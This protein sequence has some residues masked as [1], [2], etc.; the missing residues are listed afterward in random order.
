MSKLPLSLLPFLSLL[1]LLTL[2]SLNFYPTFLRNPSNAPKKIHV[3]KHDQTVAESACGGTLY[4]DLCV[5]TVAALPELRRKTLQEV[6][7]HTIN[8]T[9]KEVR[10]S[11][12][13]CTSLRR[14]LL[15]KL[16]PLE[17][18]ALEDCL[19]LFS[20]TVTELNK[21]LADLSSSA[22]PA[23]YYADLQTLLSGAMTNQY[24]CLDGFAYSKNNTR[25]FIEGRLRRISRHVS[26]S[27]AMVK[28]LK[29]NKQGRSLAAAE[30]QF[31]EYGRMRGGFPAWLSRKERRLLQA[32][33]NETRFDLVV[34][35]DGSGNFTTI[36]E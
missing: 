14:K 5:S 20:D 13:N 22:A 16:E 36:N 11:A 10:A 33:T 30:E 3:Y 19:E 17:L 32:A 1:L 35:K 12:D 18:R 25:R 4:P 9:M 34:A 2:Y 27:L 6:I 31:P 15:K 29:K 28:K 8:V 7:S 23:K 24:T 21:I 26:N